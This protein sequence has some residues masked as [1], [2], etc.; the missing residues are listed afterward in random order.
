MSP[1]P[2]ENL[3]VPSPR[4]VISISVR[5]KHRVSI[6]IALPVSLL[7]HKPNDLTELALSLPKGLPHL[8]DLASFTSLHA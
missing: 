7:P 5:P 2:P 3:F 6:V 4:A 1:C 8:P